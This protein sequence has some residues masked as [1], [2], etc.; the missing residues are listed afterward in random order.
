[1]S[2]SVILNT[3][4]HNVLNKFR[5]RL[6]KERF[7]NNQS[8][9]YYSKQNS[10]FVIPGILITGIS[11]VASFMATSDIL[12]D[13]SKKS[14][15]VGVGILT[16][17]ATILQSVSSS[18]GFQSRAEQFQ[19]AADQYDTLLTKIEFEL[20]NPNEDFNE[21][22]NEL[23]SDILQ[24]KNDCNYLPPLF[25]HKLWDNIKNKELSQSKELDSDSFIVIP[26]IKETSQTYSKA[27]ETTLLFKNEDE[28]ENY[29]SVN[30][31]Q[32]LASNV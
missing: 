12:G 13:D 18:F 31:T 23:E 17:G 11:S 10:K 16:A 5:K 2:D 29:K 26:H 21:F 25:I 19:K 3:H 28:N 4:Q 1:M 32:D 9:N 7:L 8:S 27:T 30:F 6:I 22:C 14:F 24:I 20:A 15:S